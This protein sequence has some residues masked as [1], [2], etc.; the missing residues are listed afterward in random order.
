MSINDCGTVKKDPRLPASVSAL[1]PPDLNP[2]VE[3]RHYM[4]VYKVTNEQQPSSGV[5]WGHK[6][7]EAIGR[8]R[9]IKDRSTMMIETVISFLH[10]RIIG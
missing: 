1:A 4:V 2:P 5:F 3:I 9:C 7:P 6:M 10:H 8:R